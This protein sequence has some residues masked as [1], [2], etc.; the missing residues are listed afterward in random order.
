MCTNNFSPK[1]TLPTRCAKRTSSLIDQTF[2][3]VPRREHDDVSSSI[4]LSGI[5]DHFPCCINMKILNN[6]PKPPTF[7]RTRIIKPNLIDTFRDELRNI[8]VSSRL[9]PN[10][11]T[12][13]NTQYEKFE[14][15]LSSTF[16]KHFPERRVKFYKYRHKKSKWIT[17]GI[18]K[19]IEFRDNLY[20][21][22]KICSPENPG[23]D[24]LKFNLKRYNSY[25]TQC[26]RTA[27]KEYYIHEFTKNRNDIRKTWDSLKDILNKKKS[28]SSYPPCF[29]KKTMNALQKR[30]ILQMNLIVISPKLGRNSPVQ[31]IHPVSPHLILI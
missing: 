19:S 2:C 18:L 9:D 21:Q 25:L 4:I 6:I 24:L 10:L 30:Q 7:I 1:I 5:S 14:N 26:I 20:K 16:N 23:Y 8:D 28:N 15:V 22:V 3:K 12:D 29:I 17:S 27:K 31:S 13:S 11:M